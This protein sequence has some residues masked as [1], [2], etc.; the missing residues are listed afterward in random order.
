MTDPSPPDVWVRLREGLKRMQATLD[1]KSDLAVRLAQRAQSL[2]GQRS[3]DTPPERALSLLA[4]RAGR[5]R[6]GVPVA[7]VLEVQPLDQ[8]SLV[9]GAPAEI[10]GV[11]HWRG[12]VLAL[13]DVSRLF[14]L[15]E[16]GL[17]DIHVCVI[18]EAAGQRL[19]LAA[20][21]VE[22]IHTVASDQLRPVPELSGNIDP[23]WVAGVWE[24]DRLILRL[25]GIIQ[26]LERKK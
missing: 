7:Q 3:S 21:E 19:G 1:R 6:F 5:E 8:I 11:I 2:R 12:A 23:E 4:F 22:E 18:V 15:P 9:P 10:R 24:E 14:Q 20:G 25:D 17:T 13:L 26:H 16:T